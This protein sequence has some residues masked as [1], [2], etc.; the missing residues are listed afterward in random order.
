[1]P[2]TEEEIR[3]R[4]ARA[5][6]LHAGWSVIASCTRPNERQR[7]ADAGRRIQDELVRPSTE[8][9]GFVRAP[10]LGALDAAL[11]AL[12]RDMREVA[13]AVSIA[14]LRSVVPA[15]LRQDPRG[16]LDLLDLLLGAEC[17][18][19]E[20]AP[21]LI[22][23]IDYLITALC[24]DGAETGT[25]NPRDPATLTDRLKEL[26]ARATEDYDPRLPEIEAEFFTAADATTDGV[27]QADGLLRSLA[28]RKSELGSSYFTPGVLRAIVTYNIAIAHRIEEE[29]GDTRAP[30]PRHTSREPVSR[31]IFETRA[32]LGLAK[33]L[34]RRAAGAT[35][36]PESVDRVAWALDL[37]YPTDEE[38]AALL[39]DSAGRA[40]DLEGTT[41]LFGLLWRCARETDAE[42]FPAGITW[43]EL[44]TR[45]KRE[46]EEAVDLE[47]KRR[48]AS[49]EHVAANSLA[50][51]RGRFLMAATDTAHKRRPRGN[52][53]RHRATPR[54]RARRAGQGRAAIM[55][56]LVLACLLGVWQLIPSKTGPTPVAAEVLARISPHLLRGGVAGDAFTGTLDSRWAALDSAQQTD[57]GVKLVASLR[58]Q[59]LNHIM[60][61]DDDQRLR[62]QAL[63]GA[64]PIVIGP[65]GL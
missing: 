44:D 29:V 12:E 22:P 39:A 43:Q 23:A 42:S 24:S 59:G 8:L 6:S 47:V 57:A 60:V 41:I 35:P 65:D 11:D 25:S 49:G 10:G 45:W 61:F 52:S 55:A 27:W 2:E 62:I 63:G 48:L 18:Q 3:T 40:D 37:E 21:A 14:Q 54:R 31:S 13:G 50:N 33:A 9:I 17:Q 64:P 4:V 7:I 26:C 53:R 5:R 58:A 36:G 19:D 38:R 28:A 32:L 15:Q 34:R 56:V 1:M 51:L 16:V 46:L 30:D 20:R